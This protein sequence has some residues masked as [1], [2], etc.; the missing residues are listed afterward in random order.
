M[1][2]F[3]E[4]AFQNEDVCAVE[5]CNDDGSIC[6]FEFDA[7]DSL[8]LRNTVDSEPTALVQAWTLAEAIER[9]GASDRMTA[10]ASDTSDDVFVI[11][12][13][14]WRICVQIPTTGRSKV[15]L[16]LDEE[17][18]ML[19]RG[20][21]LWTLL[22]NRACSSLPHLHSHIRETLETELPMRPATM[23]D[24]PFAA[25]CDLFVALVCAP[26]DDA[27][28]SMLHDRFH[29]FVVCENALKITSS[30]TVVDASADV[31]RFRERCAWVFDAGTSA[32][33]R[34]LEPRI[35]R[36]LLYVADN[37]TRHCCVCGRVSEHHTPHACSNEFCTFRETDTPHFMDLFSEVRRRTPAFLPVLCDAVLAALHS[38]HAAT[39]CYPI[40]RE[41]SA[42]VSTAASEVSEVRAAGLTRLL[43]AVIT[44]RRF[45]DFEFLGTL[46]CNVHIA[47]YL[48][49]ATNQ[50][51]PD[52][53]KT[54][55]AVDFGMLLWWMLR[56]I[57]FSG[58][59]TALPSSTTVAPVP[60]TVVPAFGMAA[61]S[62]AVPPGIVSEDSHSAVVSALQECGVPATLC[63]AIAA[64]TPVAVLAVRYPPPQEA[65]FR[66][67]QSSGATDPCLVHGSATSSWFN[68]WRHG[69]QI[70][71][72]TA[73]MAHGAAYGSGI[74]LAKNF[75]T[76]ASYAQS[77]A[78]CE[79]KTADEVVGKGSAL[80]IA[81]AHPLAGILRQPGRLFGRFCMVAIVEAI[82][83]AS[84]LRKNTADNFTVT[85]EDGVRMTHVVLLGV[86][87]R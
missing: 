25:L 22:V 51:K 8:S 53:P 28:T 5:E 67:L 21:E 41:F 73:Y 81:C 10:V 16:H 48:E 75:A 52:T 84:I 33:P 79:L 17:E 2:F 87:A 64:Q 14:A 13:D 57:P 65:A 39:K 40:P 44:L 11:H 6:S 34:K 74:Y 23:D 77:A 38:R 32:G 83:E 46:S 55:A 29:L 85:R 19:P 1:D 47:R 24:V 9:Q 59:C 20:P 50:S 70:L 82:D 61:P 7:D 76:S 12:L 58:A 56:A 3:V 78:A 71:S 37:L 49:F 27:R 68:I 42:A 60:V 63:T 69:I 62:T 54:G 45:V 36:A 26:D 86:H 43:D 15:K 66:E 31:A 80:E 4:S 18:H 35:V 72:E 30:T